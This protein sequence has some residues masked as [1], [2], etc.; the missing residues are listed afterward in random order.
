MKLKRGTGRAKKQQLEDVIIFNVADTR[1]AIA[2][3]TVDEIRNMDGL[4]AHK[5]GFDQRLAKV[6]FTLVR[7][8]KDR[9]K[10]YFVVDAGAHFR[11]GASKASRVLVMRN[12]SVA[13]MV[14]GIDR[15]MQISA[16][17]TIPNA[18]GGEERN[19]YRGLAVMDGKV[20]P[21]INPESF[22]SKGEI[23][24]LEAKSRAQSA[25]VGTTKGAASA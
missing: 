13:L 12:S 14:D 18:F 5:S 17:I 22:L 21:V 1:F 19:W 3:N 25:S 16:V 7:E 8:K 6:K 23:A 4:V 20:V 15:M 10:I 9:D 24:V 2:A 11:G